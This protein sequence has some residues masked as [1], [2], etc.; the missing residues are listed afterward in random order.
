MKLLVIW[1]AA[2]QLLLVALVLRG[3]L[4]DLQAKLKG[5]QQRLEVE[6]DRLRKSGWR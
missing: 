6:R 2:S 5:R 3:W 1:I 4:E